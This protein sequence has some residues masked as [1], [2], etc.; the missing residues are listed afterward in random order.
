MNATWIGIP[1][2]MMQEIMPTLD[3]FYIPIAHPRGHKEVVI[4][5][6]SLVIVANVSY[7]FC[8]SGPSRVS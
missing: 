3:K 8:D 6:G 5:L 4:S 2:L 1:S 7:Q